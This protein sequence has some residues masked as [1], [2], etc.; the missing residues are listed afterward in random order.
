MQFRDI[1][2]SYELTDEL[3]TVTLGSTGSKWP[4][5]NTAATVA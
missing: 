1:Q 4:F 2:E 3:H 5:N